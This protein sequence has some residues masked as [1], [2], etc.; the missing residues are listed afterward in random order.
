MI[1]IT[2]RVRLFSCLVAVWP[3]MGLV[4]AADRQTSKNA[5]YEIVY[6]TYFGGGQWDQAREI[7][8]Y[9]DGTVLVGGMTSSSNI[10]TT[11]D[12]IQPR[13]AGDDPSLGHGGVFGGD[14]FLVRLSPDGTRII[15]ATYFGG[16]KQERGVYGMLLDSQGN[17]VIGSATRSADMPT[18]QGAYQTQY[19]GGEADMYA[20]KLSADMKRILWCTYV[21]GSKNDWPRGGLALDNQDNVYLVGG[22]NSKDFPTTRGAFQ[23][24]LKGE[25]NAAV[26]KLSSDGSRL[27]FSTFL[28][29]SVWD[30]IM[31]VHV[32]ASGDVYVAG[33]TRSPDFP[34]TPGA[35]QPAF[36]GQSDCFMSKLSSDGGTLLYS[37]YLGGIE[38]EFA[39]HRP[40]LGPE[41]ALVLTGVS[42]SPDFPTTRGVFQRV[43]KG[44]NDGF[45]TKLAPDGKSFAFSGLLGGT[46][47][48]FFLMPTP[49]SKG[50]IF[51][52]GHTTS[53]DF[54]VTPDALPA[55]SAN[56]SQNGDGVAAVLSPDGSKLVY[57]TFLGGSGDDLI[58][59]VAI[60]PNREV[61]LV[62]STSSRD[63]PVTSNAVQ[64]ELAGGADAFLVKLVPTGK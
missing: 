45:I 40:W 17:I 53:S 25:R 50:N 52:V 44:N 48:E 5:R 35:P 28:G 39:E 21:G 56:Q 2:R 33:H 6:A 12:V 29:G 64:T 10:P 47:E 62:G 42:S 57:A 61:Y 32:D 13:Y 19:G 7:I 46:G 16:S 49:D 63:F 38:N 60:G 54:P 51:I 27:I 8:P 36:G 9:P 14:A 22:A 37:T 3:L 59:S 24:K 31:G 1:R 30:G 55:R 23:Q 20:A 18:T 15:S 41:G 58:R 43:L 4:D 26:V 34:V 11:P